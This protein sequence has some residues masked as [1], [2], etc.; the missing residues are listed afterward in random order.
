MGLTR[1]HTQPTAQHHNCTYDCTREADTVT[2]RD[3]K[4]ITHSDMRLWQRVVRM[5]YSC[6]WY[7]LPKI[8]AA[9]H[10]PQTPHSRRYADPSHFKGQSAISWRC[11]PFAVLPKGHAH[12][13]WHR[14]RFRACAEHSRSRAGSTNSPHPCASPHQERRPSRKED[15]QRLA[16]FASSVA[17]VHGRRCSMT[18]HKAEVPG[19]NQGPPRE[20]TR[21]SKTTSGCFRL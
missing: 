16:H 5:R 12:A 7:L 11:W 10:L 9:H 8:G 4:G 20:S 15:W 13:R 17:R 3:T 14:S 6:P 21:Y 1:A 18:G 19:G 2:R